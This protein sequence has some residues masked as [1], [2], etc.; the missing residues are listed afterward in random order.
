[1]NTTD[2]SVDLIQEIED[3]FIERQVTTEEA[4]RACLVLAAITANN[5][6]LTKE[7][8]LKACDMVFSNDKIEKTKELQ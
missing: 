5:L 3:M 8:F 7:F 1:M 6:H 4:H 2:R